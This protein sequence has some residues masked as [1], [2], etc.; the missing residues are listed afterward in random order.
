[1]RAWPC[2][3]TDP[4]W[5]K[6]DARLVV[7]ALLGSMMVAGCAH[8][9]VESA[10]LG[11]TQP[12]AAP[13][14]A[15]SPGE[16][17]FAVTYLPRRYHYISTEYG[18]PNDFVE[19]NKRYRSQSRDTILI[20]VDRGRVMSPS[21][22]AEVTGGFRL[23]TIGGHRAAIGGNNGRVPSGGVEVFVLVRPNLTV[24]VLDLGEGLTFEEAKRIALGVR[25]TG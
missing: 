11:S 8:A 14:S 16:P 7:S 19:V 3:A 25:A 24:D 13:T 6:P 17:D 5:R 4:G 22:Y 1:V 21:H 10:R 20:N 12:S 15:T 23:T 9:G 18:P 2:D